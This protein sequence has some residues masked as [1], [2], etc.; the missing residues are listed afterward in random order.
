[1]KWKTL[2]IGIVIGF[3]L[4]MF[5]LN[6]PCEKQELTAKVEWAKHSP[7]RGEIPSVV[8]KL[9]GYEQIFRDHSGHY[10]DNARIAQIKK[11][12]IV[13]LNICPE[14]LQTS[15][16]LPISVYGTSTI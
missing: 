7:N 14:E 16:K 1:M 10:K 4:A 2:L 13:Q 9:E 5:I 11:G 8:F 6:R 15:Q 3:I 12:T